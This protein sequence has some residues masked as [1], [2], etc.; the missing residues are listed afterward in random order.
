[1]VDNLLIQ[2]N[3]ALFSTFRTTHNK[4]ID[5]V[6]SLTVYIITN[7]PSNLLS[8]AILTVVSALY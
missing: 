3:L 7:S 4:L 2:D 5:V 6:G 8:S 1:M